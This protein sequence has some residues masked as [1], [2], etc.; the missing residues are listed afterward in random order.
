MLNVVGE[1]GHHEMGTLEPWVGSAIRQ[2]RLEAGEGKGRRQ[3]DG[4]RNEP[5]DS[6]RKGGQKPKYLWPDGRASRLLI[7]PTQHLERGSRCLL[8]VPTQSQGF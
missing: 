2:V 4:E 5:L 7:P 8:A 1:T 6:P 3:M